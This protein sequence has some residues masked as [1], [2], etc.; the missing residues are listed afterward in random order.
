L[1]LACHQPHG[2]DNASLLVVEQN[3]V[4]GLCHAGR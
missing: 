1:C 3:R 2:S 4:C